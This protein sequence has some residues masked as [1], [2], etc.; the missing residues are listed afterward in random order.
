MAPSEWTC[1]VSVVSDTLVADYFTPC[2]HTTLRIAYCPPIAVSLFLLA[3]PVFYF[4]HTLW[5]RQKVRRYDTTR[6]W[7]SKKN[8][9]EKLAHREFRVRVNLPSPIRQLWVPIWWVIT[10]IWG[11]PNPIRQGVPLISQVH[12]YPPYRSHLHQPSI[13][14]SS[15]TL[16]SLQE[17]KVKSSLFNPPCHHQELSPS[18]AYAEYSTH[19]GLSVVPSFSRF[20]VNPRI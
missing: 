8:H 17:L 7:G 11:L 14:F 4:K 18:A 9:Q 1:S 13:S 3:L 19:L 5:R 10:S 12:S 15:T 16:P 6:P 2:A 20:E